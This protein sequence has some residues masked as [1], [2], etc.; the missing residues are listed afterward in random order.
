MS[1]PRAAKAFFGFKDCEARA[2]T[3]LLQMIAAANA[4]NAR[5]DNQNIEMLNI[6]CF[7]R[8]N[9]NGL[10]V[11]HGCALLRSRVSAVNQFDGRSFLGRIGHKN[12]EASNPRVSGRLDH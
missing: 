1:S 3:L 6:A 5:A 9:L 12:T 7:S 11:S 10:T 8:V 4:G 2:W